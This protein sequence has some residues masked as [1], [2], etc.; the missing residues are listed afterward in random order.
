MKKNNIM[1]LKDDN[2]QE[3]EVEILFTFTS[4]RNSNNYIVYTDHTRDS[5][6]KEKVYAGI[7]DKDKNILNPIENKDDYNIIENIL[8]SI[9]KKN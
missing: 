6:G 1:I 5:D 8:S 7:Y 3:I 2:N 9:D 4:N